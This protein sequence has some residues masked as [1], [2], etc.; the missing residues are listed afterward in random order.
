MGKE[1]ERKEF[2]LNKN[3]DLNFIN[4][5]IWDIFFNLINF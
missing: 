2:N 3:E 1:R 5:F 4:G